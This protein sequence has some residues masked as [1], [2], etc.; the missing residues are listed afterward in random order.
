MLFLPFLGSLQVFNSAWDRGLTIAGENA[1]PCC[2]R[3]G[4]MRLVEM[5]KPRNDPDRHH[6]SFFVYQQPSPLVQG[7]MCLSDLDY[8]IKSMHGNGYHAFN[9]TCNLTKCGMKDVI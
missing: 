4:Y 9:P 7:T 5:A 3:E 6:F 2:D 8:F 1:P